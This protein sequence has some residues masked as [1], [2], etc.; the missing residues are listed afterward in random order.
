M[1]SLPC[2]ILVLKKWRLS[3]MPIRSISQNLSSFVDESSSIQGFNSLELFARRLETS[4]DI[5]SVR[6]LHASS[7]T[8]GL[9]ESIF[10]GSK[11]LNHYA[12]FG[13]L[14]ESRS[15]FD[16]IVNRNLSLWNSA[17]VGYYRAGQFEEVLWLFHKIRIEGIGIDSSA[18]TFSVKSSTELEN[19][20][21]GRSIHANAFKFG[22]NTDK[23]VGS[24]L[25]CLYSK[26]EQIDD[27]Y[28]AFQEI[29]DKDVIA[30]TSMI[31]AFSNIHGLQ[32]KMALRI[33]SDMQR[34]G[35]SANRVTL[36]SLLQAAGQLE[37][38][39]KGQSVHCYALRRGMDKFDEVLETC[40]VDMYARCGAF[41]FANFMLMKQEG[42]HVASWNALFSGYV[43]WGK[44][45][46]V[47][48]SF[49]TLMK[50]A[51]VFPDSITISN[52]LTACADL[53]CSH[54][55]K[56]IHGYIIRMDISLD[57]VVLTS[58]VDLYCGCANIRYARI[59]F[60][61]TTIRDSV[62]YNVIVSGYLCN[63]LILEAIKILQRMRHDGIRPN[64]VTMFSLLS[65]FA[66]V[67]IDTKIGKWIHGFIIR[68]DLH[69]DID[70]CNQIMHMY[71][72]WGHIDVARKIFESVKKN[73][74]SW[75]VMMVGYVNNGDAKKAILLFR[76]MQCV[77]ERPD[78]ITLVTLVQAHAQLGYSHKVEEILGYIFRF[79]L[80]KD[81]VIMNSIM[82]A[83]AK[84]GRIDMAESVFNSMEERILT[85]W[86]TFIAAYAIHGYA[87][88]VVELFDEMRK[89][90]ICP[91]EMTFSSVLSACSHGGLVE[92]G[93]RVFDIM[94]SEHLVAPAEEHYSCMVDLLGRAGHLQEAYDLVKNSPLKEKRSAL[95]S[96]LAACR[97]HNNMKLGEV[98]GK[99]LLELEPHNPSAYAL[100]SSLYSQESMWNKAA[101]LRTTSR[102]KGLRKTPGFSLIQLDI[103]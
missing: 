69:S 2:R 45:S 66:D 39:R 68:H 17:L 59:L 67:I 47:L 18:I 40:I 100:V 10:L 7:I 48:R 20:G 11:L 19:L 85:S 70:V 16:K 30:Y 33:A 93:L 3:F 27:G 83:F 1:I 32:A 80:E 54:F 76:E 13:G 82:F 65:A 58:L 43:S 28:Q 49:Y 25:V 72:K 51:K 31:T 86:N 24:S 41:S 81:S 60:D 62:F 71:A 4:Q 98:V 77:G 99:D 12:I 37:A 15:V 56:D 91:D 90:N 35:F 75:T 73:L 9:G 64:S 52:V 87:K 89:R 36:I 97:T 88:T 5:I 103:N 84:C 46:E 57:L 96:L 22:L 6:K 61:S 79:F 42:N 8:H 101:S 26:C 55:V 95:S 44:S 78:H 94:K 34:E 92:E 63:K 50:E 74:V 53:K 14:R 29:F 21:I 38:L 102:R 23:F